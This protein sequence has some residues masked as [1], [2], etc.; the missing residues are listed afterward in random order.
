[1]RSRVGYSRKGVREWVMPWLRCRLRINIITIFMFRYGQLN[2]VIGMKMDV[3][4]FDM[5]ESGGI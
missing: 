1:M 5:F 3:L 2:S 4:L